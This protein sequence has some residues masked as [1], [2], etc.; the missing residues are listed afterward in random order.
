MRERREGIPYLLASFCRWLNQECLVGDTRRIDARLWMELV[1]GSRV[2][3]PKREKSFMWRLAS[4]GRDPERKYTA[5]F[6]V[7]R[8][9]F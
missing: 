4:P 9:N 5:S 8:G 1:E 7:L 6:G 3:I 2:I